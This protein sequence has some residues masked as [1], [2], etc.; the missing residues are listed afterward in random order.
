MPA[1]WSKIGKFFDK[2]RGLVGGLLIVLVA[3]GGV[4]VLLLEQNQQPVASSEDGSQKI[5]EELRALREQNEQLLGQLKEMQGKHN[6][7]V[8]DLASK[9]VAG[10]STS[11]QVVSK[12]VTTSGKT[13]VSSTTPTG[14]I[15]INTASASQLDSLPGIGPVYAARIIEYR[16]AN[17]GFKSVEELLN[18]KGIGEK[19]LEKLKDKITI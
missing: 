1:I 7:L 13:A 12:S 3:L 11:Q 9:Q 18:I 6:Q 10:E 4:G 17:G 5:Q 14:L 8:E 19:T 15:N 2:Y 16:Q